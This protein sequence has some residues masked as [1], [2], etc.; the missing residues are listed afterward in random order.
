MVRNTHQRDLVG[1]SLLYARP[2][3]GMAF[4]DSHC[5][6]AGSAK[7]LRARVRELAA[8]GCAQE[9]SKFLGIEDLYCVRGPLRSGGQLGMTPYEERRTLA[10]AKRLVERADRKLPRAK[11]LCAKPVYF[12]ESTDGDYALL[13]FLL[14]K[15]DATGLRG[16]RRLASS[17]S[18][19]SSLKRTPPFESRDK[20]FRLVGFK[21]IQALNGDPRRGDPY[22]QLERRFRS[23]PKLRKMLMPRRSIEAFFA[24]RN[25][26]S[27]GAPKYS[28]ARR[29]S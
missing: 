7:Q 24:R 27:E 12:V 18:F 19:L 4:L 9:S 3:D 25:R 28:I 8:R 14:V 2:S 23:L 6:A 17:A 22:E 26:R 21:G 13:A 1:V 11:W 29:V 16:V 15:G 10:S 20:R 5:V